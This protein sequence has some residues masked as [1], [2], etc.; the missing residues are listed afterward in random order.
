MREVG[1]HVVWTGAGGDGGGSEGGGRGRGRG[2][3]VG[4]LTPGS[5][6]VSRA[7]RQVAD[8]AGAWLEIETSDVAE[9]EGKPVGKQR[10]SPRGIWYTASS[11][12]WQVLCT[13][14]ALF[15]PPCSSSCPCP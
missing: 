3:G 10:A 14:Y 7:L 1:R 15:V 13:R 8:A 4:A 5:F 11:G 12:L 9:E 6:D 2:R